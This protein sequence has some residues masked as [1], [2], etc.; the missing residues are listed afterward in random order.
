MYCTFCGSPNMQLQSFV[1]M[2][3]IREYQGN[4]VGFGRVF[5]S[6]EIEEPVKAGC[7]KL[8]HP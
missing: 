2:A 4:V 6:A 5:S 3:G 7:H 8:P 1:D